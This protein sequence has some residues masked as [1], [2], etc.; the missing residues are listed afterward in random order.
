MSKYL[1]SRNERV[2]LDYEE[3][4]IDCPVTFLGESYFGAARIAHSDDPV[5]ALEITKR[6][7]LVVPLPTPLTVIYS[8]TLAVGES[9]YIKLEQNG[10][11]TAGGAVDLTWNQH[12]ISKAKNVGGVI[13]VV[14]AFSN[15]NSF[16]GAAGLWGTTG[17]SLTNPAGATVNVN[18]LQNGTNSM[19]WVYRLSIMRNI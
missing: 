2:E 8:M 14:T 6:D 11:C 16:D 1:D 19:R 4:I 12:T 18:I 13:T 17:M 3:L 9:V 5:E 7:Q 15:I 10:Y